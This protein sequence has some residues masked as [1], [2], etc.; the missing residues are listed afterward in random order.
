MNLHT[1]VR[2]LGLSAEFS[3]IH[4]F[5]GG[6]AL[7]GAR[8]PGKSDLDIYGIF[9]EP[10]IKALGLD[11]FEHFVTTTSDESR[12]NTIDDIDCTLYSLRR[13]AQLAA[14]GNPTALNFLFAPNT[15]HSE[16]TNPHWNTYKRYFKEAILS[17]AAATHYI[18]FVEG[19]MRRLLGTGT[20]KH[21]QRPELVK[22]SGYDTKAAMHAVRLLGEGEELMQQHRVTFPRPNVEELLTIRTGQWSLDKLCQRVSQ[23][24]I[25]LKAAAHYSSLP[26]KP[27]R[28]RVSELVSDL[29]LWH[30]E[31]IA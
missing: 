30:Y 21:G 6:S 24:V 5:E 9:I 25:D 2:E 7:H 8:L 26:L 4:L 11:P 18:G 31:E 10:S 22:E 23:G 17:Q 16:D 12:R 20:G 13:W 3:I 15:V 27:N 28:H 29:Y 14:K 19:Q 1:K